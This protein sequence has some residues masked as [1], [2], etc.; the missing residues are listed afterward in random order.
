MKIF[1]RLRNY[2]KAW[3][4]SQYE[5]RLKEMEEEIGCLVRR[6][7]DLQSSVVTLTKLYTQQCLAAASVCGAGVGITDEQYN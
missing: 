2:Y 7:D 6:A 1:F 3:R 4:A 5:V